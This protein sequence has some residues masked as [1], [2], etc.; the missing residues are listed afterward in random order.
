MG[1]TRLFRYS[2]EGAWEIP[3]SLAGYERELQV[4]VE[5]RLETFF[6]IRL[7]A[8]EYNTGRFSRGQIDALGLDENGI[9]VI[10][11]FKRRTNENVITQG[12]Y[13]LDWLLDHQP[14]FRELVR[15]RIGGEEAEKI[16]FSWPR[17]LCIASDF[18]RFDVRAVA[19]IEKPIELLRYRF[20]ADDLVLFETVNSPVSPFQRD[21][22]QDEGSAD[23]GMPVQLQ[24]RLKG[25]SPE[26][27][28]LYLET[29]AFA[30]SMGE[31][32]TIRFLKHY[33]AISRTRNFTCIQPARGFI[34]LW[35]N[36]DPGEISLEEGFSRDVR[37]IGHH[38]SGNLELEL[39]DAADLDKARPLMELAYQ[40]N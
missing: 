35:L 7:L 6:G 36:L 30:E 27:E 29:L 1:E 12:L 39:H 37:S 5:K 23:V 28:R 24:A 19:Q 40:R 31:D 2:P 13:Y 32:V 16:D 17:I 20:F 34:K 38:A 18:N 11:E 10:I 8:H 15:E 3:A 14:E 33:V 21:G 22:Q 4:L 25:M 26:T 9:P